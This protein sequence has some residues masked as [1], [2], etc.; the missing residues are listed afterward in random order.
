MGAPI[1][2]PTPYM[3]TL[4]GFVGITDV[5]VINATTLAGNTDT[6]LPLAQAAIDALKKAA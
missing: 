6:V 2:H 4:L 1:D 3:K 5:T